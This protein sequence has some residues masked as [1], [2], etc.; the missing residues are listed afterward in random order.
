MNRNDKLP[1]AERLHADVE[2]C[3]GY[4]DLLFRSSSGN[5]YLLLRNVAHIPR[6]NYHLLSLRAVADKGH[7]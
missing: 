6:L 5:A 3:E 1:R 7:M 4:G 2:R